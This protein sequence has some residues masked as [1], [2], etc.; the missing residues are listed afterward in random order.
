MIFSSASFFVFFVSVMALYAMARTVSQR[1]SILLIASFIFYA[2]WKPVY[3]LAA[4]RVAR[5]Q[6]LRLQQAA[7]HAQPRG[8]RVRHH[9]QPGDARHFQVSRNAD[10]IGI[11][12]RG[13]VRSGC[14]HPRAGV[15]ELGA[16]A[17]HQL[18][19]VPHAER[20]DR[21]LSRRLGQAHQL[22]HVVPLR[23]VLSTPHCR[24]HS[25]TGAVDRPTGAICG[26]STSQSSPR[27]GHFRG[28][29]D[30]EGPLCRQSLAD[31]RETLRVAGCAGFRDVVARH[32]GICIPDL[33]RFLRLQRDGD[34]ARPG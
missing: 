15:G 31:R 2:S 14:R 3:V 11:V 27:C 5:N 19:H 22:P 17:G 7:R 32:A 28:R 4:G 12:D 20:D 18:L 23:H 21:R 29:T 16:A 25:A 24:A 30:Q 33:L 6:L 26:R 9:D 1:A 10:G 13:R 8:S 34:R